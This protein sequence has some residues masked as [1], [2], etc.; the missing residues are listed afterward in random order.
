[1]L[2]RITGNVV[3][4]RFLRP[5]AADSHFA[6]QPLHREP[7]HRNTITI[8]QQPDFCAPIIFRPFLLAHTS[9]ILT[10]MAE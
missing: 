4:A 5:G 1:M 6:H 10:F 2:R 3:G 8:Q 7:R 9:I